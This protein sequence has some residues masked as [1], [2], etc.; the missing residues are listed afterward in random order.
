MKTSDISD[1]V[2]LSAVDESDRRSIVEDILR[3]TY[4]DINQKLVLSKAR[5]LIRSGRMDGC[6]CGCSGYWT[7]RRQVTVD[8]V[9]A[10]MSEDITKKLAKMWESFE[11]RRL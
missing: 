9:D 4:P 7:R 10:L 5:K 3:L 1:E 11:K 8:E 6:Y 2:F